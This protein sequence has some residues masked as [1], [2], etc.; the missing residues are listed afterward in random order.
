MRL[1]INLFYIRYLLLVH[2]LILTVL[3]T[4]FEIAKSLNSSDKK[5]VPIMLQPF[6]VSPQIDGNLQDSVWND[7]VELNDFVQTF[8]GDNIFPTYPTKVFLGYDNTNLYIGICAKDDS[9]SV[10]ATLANRDDILGDDHIKIYLDTFNDNRRAYLLIFNPLGIQQDGIFV[11]G[12]EPDYSVD[13]VMESRG[14]LT[15]KGY[16]IEIAVPF[17]SLRYQSGE[18]KEWGLHVIRTIKHLNDEENSWMPLIRGNVNLLNQS[19]KISGLTNIDG[20]L[21]LEIIPTFTFSE[22]GYRIIKESNNNFITGPFK[23]D[24]GISMKLNT[25][26][27]LA[28]DFTLNPDFAQVEADQFVITANQRFPIF[29]EEK[30]PFFLEGIDIFQTPLKVVHTRTIIDPD[31]ALKMSGKLGDYTIGVLGASDNAPGSFSSEELSDPA[32]RPNI[33][34][35]IGKKSYFGITRF[36]K[37]IGTESYIG[38]LTTAYNFVRKENY[39]IGLDGRFNFNSNMALTLQFLGSISKSNFYDPDNNTE[40]F[41]KGSGLGYFINF[42]KSSRHFNL[43][44]EGDGATPDYRTKTGFIEQTNINRWALI[45][46][47]NSEPQHDAL[48][49]SWSALCTFRADFDWQG[50]MKYAYIYPRILLNFPKQTF[51]NFY[52]YSDYLKLLEEEFGPRRNVKQEGA[53]IGSPERITN[54]KGFTVEIGSTPIKEITA[55]FSIDRSWDNFDYDLGSGFRFPRVSPAALESPDAPLDPGKGNAIDI[56]SSLTY[57]T[58]ES[59]RFSFEYTK[60]R[61]FRKDTKRVAFDQ[62]I[63]SFGSTYQFTRFSFLRARFEYESL[64]AIMRAQLLVGWTPNPGTAFYIGYNEDLNYNGYNSFTQ[65]LEPGIHRNR[66]IFFL[67][68]SYV[69]QFG[70]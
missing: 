38:L 8:P 44:L 60:S 64:E 24:P 4:E 47:Y 29:F 52:V 41:R 12:T 57:L 7:A 33:E 65:K 17:H 39:T 62:N 50:R 69:F 27:N 11:E 15:S 34:E 32:I 49:I 63:Y 46:R 66:S 6:S 53:F 55:Y 61:L 59:L 14:I 28:F 2:T 35:L 16:C 42:Y 54:Y 22:R 26:S 51:I 25:T 5:S 36:K 23:G 56:Q 58:N 10:R 9:G 20:N 48:L 21:N 31:V 37:D 3:C 18:G 45:S 1:K 67:K 13:I 43:T 30:R 70:L 40:V 19:G 68:L